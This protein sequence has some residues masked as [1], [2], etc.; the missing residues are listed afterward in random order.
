MEEAKQERT[1]QKSR[2][3]RAETAL[4]N[5]LKT[6]DLPVDTVKRR[7]DDLKGKWEACQDAHDA[8]SRFSG[9]MG[10]GATEELSGW[11]DE[12]SERFQSI[13]IASDTKIVMLTP[14]VP[15]VRQVGTPK[16]DSV[17]REKVGAIKLGRTIFSPFNGDIRGY[18]RFKE[19][20]QKHLAPECRSGQLAFMLK[21]YLDDS[22]REEV[23]HC[24]EDYDA[25]WDRLD[26]RYGDVDRIVSTI[27]YE[28]EILPYG[29]SIQKD[30]ANTLKMIKVVEKAHLDLKRLDARGEMCNASM[31]T[32]IERRMCPEMVQEWAKQVTDKPISG[33]PKFELLMNFLG[34]WRSQLEY[35][36][37]RFRK[38]PE[39]KG[40]V[41]STQVHEAETSS[42]Q[43]AYSEKV[44]CWVHKAEWA[45]GHPVWSCRE[46][47]DKSVEERKRLVMDN[48]ACP[49][50]LLT[51][52]PGSKSAKDCVNKIFKCRFTGCQELHN[53]LLHS[54]VKKTL[55][56]STAHAECD[57]AATSDTLLQ[58]QST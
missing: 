53:R 30:D 39:A 12:L 49:V 36:N 55:A 8:L 17:K 41:H 24:G 19:E 22:V 38:F 33:A 47:L 7:F 16:D 23:D 13:E 4:K 57:T 50:C 27:L 21:S 40:K 52:C 5:A 45:R 15:E 28:V 10:D 34:R 46:F 1:M 54:S 11:I 58:M 20:F 6:P 18:P 26:Q 9:E 25:I 51:K 31:L 32:A 2:F 29:N 14:A 37:D 43:R 44:K 42:T 56:G 35:L 48:N 3:T